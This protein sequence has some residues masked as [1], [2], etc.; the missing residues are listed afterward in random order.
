MMLHLLF[1]TGLF[2]VPLVLLMLGHR[3]RDRTPTQRRMFWGGIIGYLAGMLVAVS[4]ALYPP[5]HWPGTDSLRG[6]LVHGAMLFF[7]LLGMVSGAVTGGPGKGD[8]RG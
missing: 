2:L 5:V 7:G 3:L 1:L 4:A 8:R 6:L